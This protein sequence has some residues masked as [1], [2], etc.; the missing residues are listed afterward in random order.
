MI[1]LLIKKGCL[2][3]PAM[4]IDVTKLEDRM[5]IKKLIDSEDLLMFYEQRIDIFNPG[6]DYQC[7]G[8]YFKICATQAE[9]EA[10]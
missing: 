8:L 5:A 4:P 2:R 9:A 10:S 7:D 6:F 3:L 1:Y